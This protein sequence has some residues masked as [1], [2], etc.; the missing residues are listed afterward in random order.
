MQLLASLNKTFHENWP[1]HFNI[2]MVDQMDE[3]C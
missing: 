2:D 1:A 3:N